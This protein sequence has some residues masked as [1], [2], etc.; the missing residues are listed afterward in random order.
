M[1]RVM[2]CPSWQHF[3]L[4]KTI[5]NGPNLSK[6]TLFTYPV[7]KERLIEGTLDVL[8]TKERAKPTGLEKETSSVLGTMKSSIRSSSK[9]AAASEM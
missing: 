9:E 5:N 3:Y 1:P 7:V 8:T 6:A 4:V 2:P